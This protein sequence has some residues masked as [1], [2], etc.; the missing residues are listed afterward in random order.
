[1]GDFNEV[2]SQDERFGST[3]NVQ[4]AAN[5]NYVHLFRRI[6]GSSFGR[7][8]MK[9]LKHLKQNVRSWVKVK[10]HSNKAQ[11]L[12]LKG[13]LSYIDSVL[14]KRDVNS[15]VLNTRMDVLNRYK[16]W[17]IEGAWIDSPDMVKNKFL[18]HFKDRFNRPGSSRFHLHM[19]FPNI[20]T[21]KQL[22]DME[23]NATKDEIN[24]AMW[25]C[26]LDKS[27][28]PDGFTFG[29]YKRYWSIIE[30][31]LM[32]AVSYFFQYGLFPSG[33]NSS[34]IALIPKMQYARMVKDFRPIS[35]IGSLYKIITK[36]L[37]NRLVTV[38]GDIV[39]EVQS[40]FIE[41]RQILD[42]L[43]ILNELIQWCK[44]KKKQTM[45]FKVWRFRNDNRSL[46]ARVIQAVHGE[47]GSLSNSPKSY[48]ASIWL[49]IVRD[50]TH[51][52]KQ[53]IDLLGLIKKKVGNGEDTLFWEDV[54]KDNV[55]FKLLYPRVYELESFKKI[56]VAA[57]LAHDNL[58]YSLRRYSRGGAEF[59]QFLELSTNMVDF[60]LPVMQDRW[61]W[62]LEGSGVFSVGS[63]RRHIDDHMLPN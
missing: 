63:V 57:K 48:R 60:Q 13:T 47:D 37:T 28:R 15:D 58:G 19:K 39:N 12:F 8:F 34:F 10:K 55:A 27:L 25:D 41:N 62:S 56:T 23:R 38:L 5:F 49:D 26:G 59:E 17:T 18:S 3:F 7:M 33:E 14:D 24:K 46:W 9:K 11:K 52:K 50:L 21:L 31:D 43:F 29:F 61:V 42:D 20:L 36:I 16:T 45:I 35:L 22:V 40:A 32:D 2:R 51:I 6:G 54:W 4:G 1:M 30:S 44:S 53:G